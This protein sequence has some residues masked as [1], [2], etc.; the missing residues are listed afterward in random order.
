MLQVY[1]R[2]Y[3]VSKYILPTL[4][5]QHSKMMFFIKKVLTN[6]LWEIWETLKEEV[7]CKIAQ[8]NLNVGCTREITFLFSWK[9]FTILI[10]FFLICLYVAVNIDID[11]H[12]NWQ[13]LLFCFSACNGDCYICNT[14]RVKNFPFTHYLICIELCNR[15]I[16]LKQKQPKILLS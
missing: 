11:I 6:L 12:V 13:N 1:F 15:Y 7:E 9:Y 3:I 14:V 10:F 5:S 8:A 2:L 16:V 4:D